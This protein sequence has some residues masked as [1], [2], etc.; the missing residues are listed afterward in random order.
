MRIAVMVSLIVLGVV[1]LVGAAGSLI[2]RS[3]ERH[4]RKPD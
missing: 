4:E 2:E 3:A 1:A